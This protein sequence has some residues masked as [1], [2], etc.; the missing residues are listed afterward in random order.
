[1]ID[2][3]RCG[4]LGCEKVGP[5]CPTVPITGRRIALVGEAPGYNEVK[6]GRPFVGESGK[7]LRMIIKQLGVDPEELF[8]TNVCICKPP[9]NRPPS[10]VEIKCCLP[11][12]LDELQ[13]FKP[14]VVIALGATA[15]K[16]LGGTTTITKARGLPF[17]HSLGFTVVP[18]LHPAFILRD[19]SAF[20]DLVEDLD[21][22]IN[23]HIEVTECPVVSYIFTDMADIPVCDTYIL[24][25]ETTGRNPFRDQI[26]RIGLQ[27]RGSSIV[28]I[29]TPNAEVWN[30]KF[31]Q[32]TL[33]GHNIN[34][35]WQFLSQAGLF[36]S[37]NLIDTMLIHYCLD[38]RKGTHALKQLVTKYY[39]IPDYSAELAP[40]KTTNYSLIPDV[41]LHQYLARDCF[42]T[43]MLYEKFLDEG[44]PDV[45]Y[46]R[47]QKVSK[48]SRFMT[49]F[50]IALDADYVVELR[51]Q[52]DYKARS[53]KGQV[54]EVTGKSELN[55]NSPM[56]ISNL[57]YST[58]KLP[59]KNTTDE[60]AL[61]GFIA[62]KNKRLVAVV[63][64]YANG[65]YET[66]MQFIPEHLQQDYKVWFVLN[67][68]LDYRKLSKMKSTYCDGLLSQLCSDGRIHT[69]FLVHGT[70][71]G[72]LSSRDP[73]LQNIPHHMES[74]VVSGKEIRRAF[75]ADK[76]WMFIEAD[77]KQLEIHVLAYYSQDEILIEHLKSV[78]IH[79]RTAAAI[80]HVAE[81]EVTDT[82]RYNA[83][84]MNFGAIYG[85][86]AGAISDLLKISKNDA[87]R[88][89]DGWFNTYPRV[90]EWRDSIH[91]EVITN[92]EIVTPLGR[93]RRFPCIL[94]LN[95]E[96]VL[97]Q[98]VNF[99]VQSLAGDVC[100][101]AICRM[102]E[103]LL[104][105]FVLPVV[106]VHDSV[107]CLV[108]N[109]DLAYDIKS[110][111]EQPI[112]D[113]PV[114]FT[115]DLKIGENWG[116]MEDLKI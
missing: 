55:I 96:E 70:E 9:N 82:Q 14:E 73:N 19:P 48:A 111:M 114:P 31:G 33:I 41:V 10:P 49:K 27:P 67:R 94:N 12:L 75:V 5:S 62:D 6:Q 3:A 32:A 86:G 42:F 4:L 61:K 16:A 101:L 87:Q 36:T 60:K 102:L 58:W 106:A 28:Y 99:P 57:L 51:D 97:R 109:K 112:I 95:R 84:R 71:T 50:G 107:L 83:K 93:V 100:S 115:V 39:N 52:L 38:E 91:E 17:L 89:I 98:A 78:D 77:Y 79:R 13:T 45:Y 8:I 1:M 25:I 22:A 110:V 47:V 64:D 104:S 21:K 85:V 20:N 65:T 74:S 66:A 113:A 18:T 63:P 90:A 53:I 46:S 72:R 15:L 26:H 11:R 59:N 76:G 68:I 103:Q 108:P 92:R 29:T 35:D 40:Y 23:G 56:Q 69:N 88:I 2:C 81:E 116:E 37:G 44:I 7:L 34:F 54:T 80:Y 105:K 30:A 24:D 43:S